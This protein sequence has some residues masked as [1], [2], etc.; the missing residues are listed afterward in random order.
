MAEVC[1][2]MANKAARGA[3][4]IRVSDLAHAFRVDIE[5]RPLLVEGLI[6]RPKSTTTN[7]GEK[8]RWKILIDEDLF[9]VETAEIYAESASAPLPERLRFTIAHE[10]AHTL[11]FRA[12]DLSLDL[13]GARGSG[14]ALVDKLE[15]EANT[16]APL[17]LVSDDSL[18][19]ES[20]QQSPFNLRRLL[21]ARARWAISRT[22][23]VS[24][25]NILRRHDPLGL[26]TTR[27]FSRMLLGV[28]EWKNSTNA[29][30][31]SWPLFVNFGDHLLPEFAS[32][33]INRASCSL[34]EIVE[35][36][37]G[38]LSGDNVDVFTATCL[39][40]TPRNPASEKVKFS[41]EIEKVEQKSGNQFLFRVV[42]AT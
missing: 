35:S 37:T 40:G 17:L 18:A 16:L 29:T 7:T 23:L 14:E 39:A 2:T 27:A 36:A 8:T 38:P 26:Y 34:D 12:D 9:A 21:Y 11:T 3:D 15:S 24:R 42:P 25:F 13:G 6:A 4:F 31:L 30:L 22:V 33:L 19:S 20:K 10:L 41:V 5:A 32:R 28:G 1:S